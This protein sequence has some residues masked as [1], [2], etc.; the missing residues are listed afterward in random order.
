LR[1]SAHRHRAAGTMESLHK[2]WSAMNKASD[3]GL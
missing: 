3:N 1:A 2:R